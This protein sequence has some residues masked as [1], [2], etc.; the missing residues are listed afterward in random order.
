MNAKIR[1]SRK[2]RKG[3]LLGLVLVI[4]ICLA[5]LGFG[6]LQMGFGGRVNAAISTDSI[7]AR[8][9]ADAGLMDALYQMNLNFKKL[10]AF[11]TSPSAE[12][13]LANMNAKY[14]FYINNL[15]TNDFQIDSVGTSL[16]ETRTVHAITEY[17]SM[18]DY[19]LFVTNSIDMR[20]SGMIDA[21]DSNDGTYGGTNAGL[22]VE[23]GSETEQP[24]KGPG[25]D[26]GIGLALGVK[27][28]GSVAVG[29]GLSPEEIWGT[30][31]NG[32]LQ[33]KNPGDITGGAF[34]PSES[35][36]WTDPRTLMP[37]EGAYQYVPMTGGKI[38]NIAVNGHQT[39]G[40]DLVID[41][42][43]KITPLQII[44]C[45]D[46]DI[47]AGSVLEIYSPNPEAPVVINVTGDLII[48]QGA[49]IVVTNGSA[50]TIFLDGN[51]NAPP[52]GIKFTNLTTP[53]NPAPKYFQ[54]FGT[55]NPDD[56]PMKW[57]LGNEGKFY[58][59]I[60]APNADLTFNNSV[61]IFGSISARSCDFRNSAILHY[62]L[63]LAEE[64]K[65]FTGYVIQRWW[66]EGN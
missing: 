39:I 46:L 30:G 64:S 43:T 14:V 42:A 61:E 27:I 47:A 24:Y 60:Y 58:G 65:F 29:T 17:A 20:N 22:F 56:G 63:T 32:V 26:D 21:Y 62:D 12:T 34:S 44:R 49:E 7:N 31:N 38:D 52:N 28:T 36:I 66:E 54:I 41:G 51:L 59:I 19:A 35:Y 10:G 16:R 13:S 18:F 11:P 40:T 23:V 5:L 25:Q 37:A 55:S 53:T 8:I 33:A 3:S 4:G 57:T 2:F 9:A 15:A 50:L 6:M 1:Y 45:A 48:G